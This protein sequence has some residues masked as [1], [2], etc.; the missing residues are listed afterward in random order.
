MLGATPAD[1]DDVNSSSLGRVALATQGDEPPA[2]PGDDALSTP[3]G[4]AF[5]FPRR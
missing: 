4:D 2:A 5:E 3:G 1:A